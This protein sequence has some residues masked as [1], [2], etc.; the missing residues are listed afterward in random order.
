MLNT[1][2]P[3]VKEIEIDSKNKQILYYLIAN[4]W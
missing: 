4:V 3:I 2:K 1:T